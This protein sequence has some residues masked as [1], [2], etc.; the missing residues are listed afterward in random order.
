[1]TFEIDATIYSN[2]SIFGVVPSRNSVGTNGELVVNGGIV[3]A[4]I[5]LLAPAGFKLRYDKRGGE[6]I[7]IRA[8]NTVRLKRLLVAHPGRP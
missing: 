1:M 6:L 7:D 2:N 4:D 5:G 8:D 3:A